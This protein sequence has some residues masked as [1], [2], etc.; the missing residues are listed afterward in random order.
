MH[1]GVSILVCWYISH[2]A[3]SYYFRII[4]CLPLVFT[5][6]RVRSAHGSHTYREFMISIYIYMYIPIQFQRNSKNYNTHII[7]SK[8]SGRVDYVLSM[9]RIFHAVF[10]KWILVLTGNSRLLMAIWMAD[11]NIYPYTHS[12]IFA[13]S[14][15][16]HFFSQSLRVCLLFNVCTHISVSIKRTAM[17]SSLSFCIYGFVCCHHRCCCWRTLSTQMEFHRIFVFV[18]FFNS[19]SFNSHS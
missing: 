5:A 12:N 8:V 15:R 1:L 14:A 9:Y 2:D 7:E 19:E 10:L 18:F 3:V 4:S 11:V 13:F 16:L 6:S 17:F